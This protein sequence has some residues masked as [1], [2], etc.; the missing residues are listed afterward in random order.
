MKTS[1]LGQFSAYLLSILGLVLVGC[2]SPASSIG[3]IEKPSSTVEPTAAAFQFYLTADQLPVEVTHASDPAV[4]MTK[5]QTLAIS[6]NDKIAVGD[7]G[8]GKLLYSDRIAVEILQGTELVM[9]NV[10]PVAGD[11]IEA[12][13]IQNFGHTHFTIGDNAKAGVILKTDDSTITSL[14]D[15]TEFSVCYAPGKD[16]LTCHPVLKGSIQVFGKTG[17]SQVYSAP[18]MVGAYTFNGQAPQPPICFHEQEYKDWLSQMRN[19]EKV[20]ALGALVDKWYKEPCPDETTSQMITPSPVPMSTDTPMS[21]DSPTLTPMSMESSAAT[22]TY[23][24]EEFN[25]GTDLTMWPSFQWNNSDKVETFPEAGTPTVKDGFLIFDIQKPNNTTFVTYDPSSYG[26]IK[27]SL[28]AHNSGQNTSSISLLCR[29][30]DEGWYEFKIGNDGLYSILGYMAVEKK[31]YPL[32]TGGSNSIHTGMGINEYSV[33]CIGNELS[34]VI[35]GNEVRSVNDTMHQLGEGKVGIAVSSGDVF[36][37]LEE[38][39]WFKTEKP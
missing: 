13:F 38:I 25:D 17:K 24:T 9:G 29:Y 5:G 31:Y 11:R 2:S 3:S 20:E 32:T 15:A 4:T 30:S 16:G 6:L 35:N 33:T 27:I 7:G 10:I 18:P 1:K 22:N 8:I 23:F 39:N 12:S 14:E 36:P 26:D 21:M 34:L 19:G 37:I 28:S